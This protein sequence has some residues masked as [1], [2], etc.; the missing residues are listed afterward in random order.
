MSSIFLGARRRAGQPSQL[1]LYLIMF[2]VL[3]V[4]IK[5]CHYYAQQTYFQFNSQNSVVHH[6]QAFHV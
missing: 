4:P 2:A 1:D 6:I 3:V 5:Y